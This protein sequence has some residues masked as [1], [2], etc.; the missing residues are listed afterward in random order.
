MKKLTKIILIALVLSFLAG[1]VIVF[2]GNIKLGAPLFGVPLM[3]IFLIGYTTIIID[4]I[5]GTRE[6]NLWFF[7]LLY[8]LAY[9]GLDH[10]MEMS[11]KLHTGFNQDIFCLA[12]FLD[13]QEISPGWEI[14]FPALVVLPLLIEFTKKAI[15]FFKKRVSE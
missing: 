14:L 6:S 5:S 1:S 7:V 11:F 3:V 2:S 10:I 9:P 13:S 12:P 8:I 4:R 15:D